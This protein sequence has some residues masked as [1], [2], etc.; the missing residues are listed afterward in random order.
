LRGSHKCRPARATLAADGDIFCG[1]LS[2]SAKAPRARWGTVV[3]AAAVMPPVRIFAVR[4]RLF[5]EGRIENSNLG[6]PGSDSSRGAS[7]PWGTSPPNPV[8]IVILEDLH[9]ADEATLD[10]HVLSADGFRVRVAC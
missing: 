10:F 2:R 1:I 3:A 5:V 4:T 6:D 9:W 8:S 7:F